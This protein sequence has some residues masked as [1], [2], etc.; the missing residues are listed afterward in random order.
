MRHSQRPRVGTECLVPRDP[1]QFVKD[2]MELNKQSQL[3]A[4]C[5]MKLE[6]ESDLGGECSRRHIM[7]AT[8]C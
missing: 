8:E 1:L 6:M 3:W 7:G 4:T 2:V 5:H